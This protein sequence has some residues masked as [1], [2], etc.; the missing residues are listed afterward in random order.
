MF[1]EKKADSGKVL[2]NALGVEISLDEIKIERAVQVQFV[3]ED[4]RKIIKAFTRDVKPNVV[5]FTFL[6][7]EHSNN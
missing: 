2:C 1:F 6:K 3:E 7:A 5:F 4:G